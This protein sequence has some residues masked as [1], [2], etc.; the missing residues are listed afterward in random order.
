MEDFEAK[1]LHLKPAHTLK[2]W[3]VILLFLPIL[4]FIISIAY[5]ASITPQVAGVST[6]ASQ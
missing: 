6:E 5:V 2:A 3:H 4:G 1:I